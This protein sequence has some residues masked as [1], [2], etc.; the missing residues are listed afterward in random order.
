MRQ[1]FGRSFFFSSWLIL[2]TVLILGVAPAAGLAQESSNNPPD[3]PEIV[4]QPIGGSESSLMAGECTSQTFAY[5]NWGDLWTYGGQTFNCTEIV[6][7][8]FLD[9]TLY[10]WD[11]ISEEWGVVLDW[12][13]LCTFTVSCSNGRTT[14]LW[15]GAFRVVTVHYIVP[16]G[17]GTPSVAVTARN[18]YV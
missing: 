12:Q 13:K 7:E 8:I 5:Q 18:F 4:V 9:N 15:P 1:L 16:V 11:Q 10:S 17:G 2:V 3:G 6:A 14:A